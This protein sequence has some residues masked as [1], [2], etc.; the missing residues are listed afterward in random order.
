MWPMLSGENTTSPRT[1]IPLSVTALSQWEEG[2]FPTGQGLI[3]G[4]YKVVFDNKNDGFWT[5]PQYPNQTT[6]CG[7]TTNPGCPQGC[8]FNINSDP[9]EYH[10]LRTM[11]PAIF[12]SLTARLQALSHEVFQTTY[13]LNFNSSK[14]IPQAQAV[15]QHHGF[16]AP[17]CIL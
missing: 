8:L 14:C 11:Q 12:A 15:Q 7:S 13:P 16:S 1:E 9:S 5:S 3:V 10:D 4:E 6:Q 17:Q 2:G